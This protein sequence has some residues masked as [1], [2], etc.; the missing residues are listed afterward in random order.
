MCKSRGVKSEQKNSQL[1]HKF[2]VF[3]SFSG[4]L[5]MGVGSIL[6]SVP[7]FI[8]EANPSIML[9]NKTDD[10]ICRLVSVREQDMGLGRL[11]HHISKLANPALATHNNLR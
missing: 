8:G 7:H 3:D 5:I 4:A 2:T 1:S 6:F 10:N 11:G 9:N